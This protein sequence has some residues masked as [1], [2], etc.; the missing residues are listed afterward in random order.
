[1]HL[2]KSTLAAGLFAALA[3]QATP[4]DAGKPMF[5]RWRSTEPAAP[6]VVDGRGQPKSYLN[7]KN[8]TR[9]EPSLRD[10]RLLPHERTLPGGAPGREETL[11]ILP[12]RS[13]GYFLLPDY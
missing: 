9:Y 4:A 1:M 12:P 6:I 8:K 3:V 7:L 2:V 10:V 5:S 13:N 11:P